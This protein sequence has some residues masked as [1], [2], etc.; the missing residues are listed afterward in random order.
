MV[1]SLVYVVFCALAFWMVLAGL[2]RVLGDRLRTEASGPGSESVFRTTRHAS[3]VLALTYATATD[4]LNRR[5]GG[6]N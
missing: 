6:R 1:F 3:S 2:Q 4:E 5:A